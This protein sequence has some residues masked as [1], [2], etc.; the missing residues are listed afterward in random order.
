MKKKKT[1]ILDWILATRPWSFAVSALPAFVALM[2]TIHT[3]PESLDNWL[4]GAMAVIGAVI[5]HAGGNLISDYNDFR[6]GVDKE[7][8]VGADTL[9]SGLF[10]PKQIV[11]YGWVFIAIGIALGLFLLWQVGIELLWIGVFGVI[12]A[13]FYY[14]FKSNALGDLLIFLVYGP[15]IMLGTGYVVLGHYD[16]T[17]LFVSFPMAFITV[18]VLH[19]NNTRDIRNDQYANIKT[20]A[21]LIGIKASIYY[22]YV[23]TVLSY[24]SIIV[25]LLIGILPITTIITLITIPIAVKNC[26]AMSQVTENDVTP[27]NNLDKNT[28]QLQLSFSAS[29][30]LALIISIIL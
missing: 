26:K 29:L 3:H 12:G 20:F 11:T 15:T 24:V 14:Q 2:Y 8:N 7:D 1:T 18:N 28:A 21:M 6:H 13:V 9:T 22:Y 27:I 10:L 5:F 4:Y 23:M 16:W 19:C 25:M 17:L 30:L